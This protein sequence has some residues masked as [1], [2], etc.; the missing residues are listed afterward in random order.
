MVTPRWTSRFALSS[1]MSSTR[2][3]RDASLKWPG[4]AALVERGENCGCRGRADAIR[5]C[6]DHR[7][8]VGQRANAAR[9][10]DAEIGADV[11]A[12]Q[13]HVHNRCAARRVNSRR[14]LDESGAC[15]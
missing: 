4:E 8:R 1:T 14:R 11:L 10:L 7:Q 9:R 12:Q 15:V 13:T 3:A 2:I 6:V 5:T